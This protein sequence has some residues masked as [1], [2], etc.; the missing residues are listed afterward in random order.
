MRLSFND[1]CYLQARQIYRYFDLE[2]LIS[3]VT[4]YTYL[5]IHLSFSLIQHAQI[6]IT[7]LHYINLTIYLG[8]Q[9]LD[10]AV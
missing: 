8:T 9:T 1:N 3:N 5:H 6:D 2:L 4:D 7:I 10:N